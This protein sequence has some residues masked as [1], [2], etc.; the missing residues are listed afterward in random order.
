ME[1]LADTITIVRHFSKTGKI[2]GSARE[3]ISG[4]EHGEH[5]LFISIISLVEIMY[6]SQKKRIKISLEETLERINESDNY[7]VVDLTAQIVSLAENIQF[8][9][10]FDRLIIA[11]A[12]YLGIPMLTSDEEIS[13]TDIIETIWK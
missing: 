9:E 7:S 6:L 5:H 12:K 8:P 13:A 2:G 4:V 11:T 3:I 1:Y 10:I